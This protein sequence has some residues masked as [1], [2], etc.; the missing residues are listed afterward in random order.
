MSRIGTWAPV[1]RLLRAE[2]DRKVWACMLCTVLLVMGS[3]ALAAL[4]PLALKQLVDAVAVIDT[5]AGAS[6]LPHAAI[7]L[8][9]LC[10]GRL[11]ADIRPLFSNRIEQ[12]MNAQ[13]ARRFFDQLLRLPMGYLVK[14]R[15]GELLHSLDLAATGLQLIISHLANSLMPVLVEAATMTVI[16]VKLGQPAIVT[17]FAFTAAVYLA[18]FTAG[19]LQITKPAD[20]VSA[21]SLEIYAQLNDGIANVE[22]LRAFVAEKQAI[23][24]LRRATAI[25]EERW[26]TL[27]RL[28]A[29]VAL[30]ASLTFTASMAAC[31]AVAAQAV[32]HGSLTVG[33][34]VLVNVYALQMVRPLEVL[35]SAAR[36]LSRALSYVRPLLHI[37]AEPT[38]TDEAPQEPA[39]T[40]ELATAAQPGP[41]PSLRLENVHFGYETDRP[42]IKGLDLH[43]KAGCTTAI[44]G[45]SGCGKSS[46]VRL[47]MRLY[48]PQAGCILLDGRPI[49]TLSIAH[50]RSLIGLM[51]QDAAL[52]HTSIAS[53]IALGKPEASRSD[54]ELAARH[55]QL[56]EVIKGFPRGYDTVVG[57]RGLQLSGGER[58]RVVIARALLRRPALY[59]LDEPTSM[60]DSKT[61][62]AIL[63]ALRELTVGCTTLV[64]AH[65]LLTVMHA[66]E[67]VVMDDG[68]VHER[69]RHAELLCKG[70][71]YADLWRQQAEGS[72]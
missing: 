13:L 37:L 59:V 64:I 14:R 4:S 21:A 29:K 1:L 26:L 32:A 38:E 57:E 18:I 62:A 39:V 65:R 34:F 23:S 35:G 16:L 5:N 41:A 2:A 72:V 70:G 46:L 60:L 24:E 40:V 17:V 7:Y 12:R 27:N 66:D 22:T 51:P 47:L 52:L 67:I 71:L 31:L 68:Q 8:L 56:H 58:Q 36:D 28:N 61:E 6:A 54:I 44:V 3:G 69:G 30:G 20:A 10:A 49:E 43:V 48:S 45:R 19:A 33:G 15:S 50:L 53:N 42:V 25:L 63:Q 11:L 55:A 9:V